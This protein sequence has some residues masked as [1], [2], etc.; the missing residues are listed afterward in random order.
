VR[1]T[2]RSGG[3]ATSLDVWEG[4]AG[5]TA[6][7]RVV[8]RGA[9]PVLIALVAGT[10]AALPSSAAPTWLSPPAT[11]LSEFSSRGQQPQVGIDAAGNTTVIWRAAGDFGTDFVVEVA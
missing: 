9:L 3:R 2:L 6:V 11:A 8:R 7:N 1:C 4:S 5:E 10:V